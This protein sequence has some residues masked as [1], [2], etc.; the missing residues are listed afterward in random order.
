VVV[1]G[2]GTEK[3]RANGELTRLYPERKVIQV[4]SNE[5]PNCN[6]EMAVQ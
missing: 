6:L 3:H 5:N 1:A 4:K 2:R